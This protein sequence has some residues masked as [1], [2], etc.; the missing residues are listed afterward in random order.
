VTTDGR[1]ITFVPPPRAPDATRRQRVL[2]L[3]L[4]GCAVAVGILG[5]AASIHLLAVVPA[6]YDPIC[7]QDP[8]FAYGVP[9]ALG[10]S[11]VWIAVAV[12]AAFAAACLATWS[13]AKVWTVTALACAAGLF[14]E[15]AGF[16]FIDVLSQSCQG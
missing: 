10:M 5:A 1:R 2:A 16:L 8:D 6:N 7:L 11:Q 12:W 15:G 13:A 3:L 4:F 14:I 9:D